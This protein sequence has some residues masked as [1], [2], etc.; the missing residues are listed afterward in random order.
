MAS[1]TAGAASTGGTQILK[2]KA[3][4]NMASLLH[5]IQAQRG[6]AL[7]A[8]RKLQA[9]FKASVLQREQVWFFSYVYFLVMEDLFKNFKS[10]THSF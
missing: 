6:P 8:S 1:E 5:R 2:T 4:L 3:E 9:W 10:R 7:L